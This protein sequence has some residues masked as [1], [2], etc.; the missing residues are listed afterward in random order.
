MG[1]AWRKGKWVCHATGEVATDLPE[2][3]T[4]ALRKDLRRLSRKFYLCQCFPFNSPARTQK[5]VWKPSREEVIC[6]LAEQVPAEVVWLFIH[7]FS[8]YSI[9]SVVPSA[10]I[11][12]E[13][14]TTHNPCHEAPK[15]SHHW[16]NSALDNKTLECQ[17][18]PRSPRKACPHFQQRGLLPFTDTSPIL[19]PKSIKFFMHFKKIH[20]LRSLQVGTAV[21]PTPFMRGQGGPLLCLPPPNPVSIISYIRSADRTEKPF[22]LSTLHIQAEEQSG[23]SLSLG[24]L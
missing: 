20:F 9:K 6:S 14:R 13:S 22:F 19:T 16:I 5:S 2:M 1:T 17:P 8:L 15:G 18:S 10:V 12:P 3:L 4:Q 11:T 24:N 7:S 21:L 23:I